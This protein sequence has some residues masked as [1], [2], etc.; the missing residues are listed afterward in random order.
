MA[1]FSPPSSTLGQLPLPHVG[2]HVNLMP[3][4]TIQP[5]TSNLPPQTRKRQ[6]ASHSQGVLERLEHEAQ[7]TGSQAWAAF[8]SFAWIWPI[9]GLLYSIDRERTKPIM[10]TLGGDLHR[11]HPLQ[12]HISSSPC[13][14]HSSSPS[15]SR[16]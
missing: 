11:T 16:W 3:E 13:V 7:E 5:C 15:W 8:A 2:Q 12:T 1:Y 4:T 10:L 9:R 14:M 6:L